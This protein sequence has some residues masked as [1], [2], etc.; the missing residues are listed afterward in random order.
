MSLGPYLIQSINF[1]FNVMTRH[2]LIT[3]SKSWVAKRSINTK[4]KHIIF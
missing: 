1:M 4:N 3:M 2:M